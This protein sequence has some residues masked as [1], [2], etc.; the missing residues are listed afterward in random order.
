MC[1]R[2]RANKEKMKREKDW[3]KEIKGPKRVGDQTG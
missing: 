1:A 3:R 2:R